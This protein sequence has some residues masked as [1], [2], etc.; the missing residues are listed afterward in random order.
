MVTLK[1]KKKDQHILVNSSATD[2]DAYNI[3][4]F[5]KE[6]LN[7]HF[8]EAHI[9]ETFTA[10][11]RRQGLLLLL[12]HGCSKG[13]DGD[14]CMDLALAI[15]N[16]RLA[17]LTSAALHGDGC[18]SYDASLPITLPSV[19]FFFFLFLSLYVF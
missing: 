8:A 9:Q 4:K 12:Q 6:L 2:I 16:V 1:I 19:T 18:M 17:H 5:L 11:K 3:H 15:H 7:L 14:D 13:T 10:V